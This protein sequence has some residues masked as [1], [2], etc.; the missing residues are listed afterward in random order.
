MKFCCARINKTA[1]TN[2]ISKKCIH[3]HK[4][5]QKLNSFD[6]DLRSLFF[7]HFQ[8]DQKTNNNDNNKTHVSTWQRCSQ[9]CYDDVNLY[10][11]NYRLSA[12]NVLYVLF[13]SM[14][15]CMCVFVCEFIWKQREKRKTRNKTVF[16]PMSTRSSDPCV[17]ILCWLNI[18]LCRFSSRWEWKKT[19][20]FPLQHIP[21]TDG[22]ILLCTIAVLHA[23]KHRKST[24]LVYVFVA[25]V[26][27][28]TAS[29][30]HFFK[31]PFS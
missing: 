22:F 4:Y 28:W 5:N 31:Y 17:C 26:F 29:I 6:D 25:I 30:Q 14:L 16:F 10:I 2:E 13:G 12:L 27:L 24:W 19:C 8:T 3:F 9:E 11:Y 23:Y 7:T 15:M 21:M 18:L 20:V 1:R